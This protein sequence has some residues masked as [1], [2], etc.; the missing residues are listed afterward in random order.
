MVRPV[1]PLIGARHALG[2][3]VIDCDHQAIADWWFRLVHCDEMQFPFFMAR[4][5]RL[6]STHF[7]HEAALM[8]LA[9]GVLCGCHRQEHGLL[10]ELCDQAVGES[11]RNWRK[12]QGLLRNRFPKMM[13]D[14]IT[15][16]DQLTVLFIHTNTQAAHG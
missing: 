5:K 7:D 15:S 11:R 6:M 9:G 12:A 16:M 14:H 10:L 8:Q 2:H 1:R 4:L 3:D 13:R